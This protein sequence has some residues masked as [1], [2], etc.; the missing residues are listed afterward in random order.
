MPEGIAAG[1]GGGAL[2]DQRPAPQR[3][4]QLTRVLAEQVLQ[5]ALREGMTE[6]G[7][8]LESALATLLAGSFEAA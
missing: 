2:L 8:C 4:E 5:W 3:P 6:H 7:G 1:L